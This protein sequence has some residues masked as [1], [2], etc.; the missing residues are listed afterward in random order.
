MLGGEDS[1][2][3]SGREEEG[4]LPFGCFKDLRRGSLSISSSSSSS[5][6]LRRNWEELMS[7]EREKRKVR[8]NFLVKARNFLG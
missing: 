5:R 3:G 8:G 4:F 2:E 1:W 6:R 7:V